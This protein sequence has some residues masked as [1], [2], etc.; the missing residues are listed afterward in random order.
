MDAANNNSSSR[1]QTKKTPSARASNP[2]YISRHL[3]KSQGLQLIEGDLI[4]MYPRQG[5]IRWLS[6]LRNLKHSCKRTKRRLWKVQI[7]LRIKKMKKML[8][9]GIRQSLINQPLETRIKQTQMMI[10]WSKLIIRAQ[11]QTRSL[12]FKIVWLQLKSNQPHK[13]TT[14]LLIPRNLTLFSSTRKKLRVITQMAR[15]PI[16]KTSQRDKS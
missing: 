9:S 3:W 4:I 14:Q 1:P 12:M 7:K 5:S 2:T 10:W 13:M 16:L 11:Q 6:N 15:I 8:E